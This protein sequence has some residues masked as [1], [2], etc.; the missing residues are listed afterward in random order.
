MAPEQHHI[1]K[2]ATGRIYIPLAV[3]LYEM[4]NGETPFSTAAEQRYV[5]VQ[6]EMIFKSPSK[7]NPSV[8]E[9]SGQAHWRPAFTRIPRKKGSKKLNPEPF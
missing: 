3:T 8:P 6:T 5:P 1:G 2:A 7:I 4:D 9:G